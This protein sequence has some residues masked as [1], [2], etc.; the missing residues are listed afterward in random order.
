MTARS[1][2]WALVILVALASCRGR[3]DGASARP[4]LSSEALKTVPWARVVDAGRGG[5]VHWFF[6]SGSPT[7]NRYVDEYLAAEV[8]R[9]YDI[10][11]RRVPLADAALGINRLI[12]EK[13]AGRAEGRADLIWINGENFRLGRDRG[14]FWGPFADRLPNMA[15]VDASDPSITHD[16]G[17][18]TEG[19]EAPWSRAQFVMIFDSA[20]VKTPPKSMD[21]LSAFVAAHPGRFT[22][23]AP[24]DFTGSA[25]LRQALYQTAGGPAAFAAPVK[26]GQWDTKRGP[27]I[28]LL[29]EWKPNLWRSGTTYPP[30]SS[31]L[32][33]L[34][35]QGEVWL[36]MSYGPE[37]ASTKIEDGQFPPT[38]RT[39][40]F[41]AGT[42]ANTSFVAIPFNAAHKAAAMVVANFL[43]SVDAQLS[44]QD[45]AWWGSMTVLAPDKLSPTDA[46]RFSEV[47]RGPATLALDVLNAAAVSEADPSWN[48]A[49]ERTW[50]EEI[51]RGQ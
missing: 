5:E 2:S 42:L 19:F 17:V 13:K 37:T 27:L 35:G 10:T 34:F 32:H 20:K 41:D 14:L 40:V 3:H 23:P 16:F 39:Y 26:A 44:K 4:Q 11:L 25:F 8:R 43:L 36:S 33:Q 47:K 51:A 21:E 1:A 28:A 7:I 9:R 30:S 49:L 15:H 48:E 50:T 38:T 45:P 12:A 6:W 46:A 24:P 18:A 22:Y 29:K 31:R